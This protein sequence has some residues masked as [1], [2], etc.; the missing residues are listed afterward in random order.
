MHGRDG[1]T[2]MALDRLTRKNQMKRQIPAEF[3]L[4]LN[5][6]IRIPDLGGDF[7]QSSK[8][9]VIGI[10]RYT[11]RTAAGGENTW[12]SYTLETEHGQRFW[13]V[14]GQKAVG[15]DEAYLPRSFYVPSNDNN[16]PKGCELDRDLSGYVELRT[17][18][19]SELSG[20]ADLDIG[21]LFTYRSQ[22]GRVWAEETFKGADRITFD[23][24][25]EPDDYEM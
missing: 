14:D 25:F 20:G 6:E 16:P 7:S 24:V 17:E 1:L 22:D 19:D 18:G 12:V 13:A 23:A 15:A 3:N 21:A 2:R 4:E 8:A 5:Q 11:E 10:D 9:S